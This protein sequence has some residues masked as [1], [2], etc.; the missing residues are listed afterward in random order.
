MIRLLKLTILS[1]VLMKENIPILRKYILKY[2]GIKS[3][4]VCNL[5]SDGSEK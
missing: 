2:L 3:Y 1:I 5:H 4:D